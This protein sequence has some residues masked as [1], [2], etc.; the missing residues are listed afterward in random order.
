MG[1]RKLKLSKETIKSLKIKSEVKTGADTASL[2][3]QQCGAG[4]YFLC[5]PPAI[6]GSAMCREMTG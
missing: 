5:S 4:T 1:K 2:D 3:I 6:G